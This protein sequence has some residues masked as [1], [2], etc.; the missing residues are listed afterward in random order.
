MHPWCFAKQNRERGFKELE[1]AKCIEKTKIT[2]R[3]KSRRKSMGKNSRTAW[4]FPLRSLP[5]EIFFPF[6]CPFHYLPLEEGIFWLSGNTFLHIPGSGSLWDI[7]CLY[8]MQ[9]RFQKTSDLGC[10]ASSNAWKVALNL[11]LPVR[12]RWTPRHAKTLCPLWAHTL[13][14]S[15]TKEIEPE[16]CLSWSDL[17]SCLSGPT[18][19]INNVLG[20]LLVVL[21]T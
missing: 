12:C 19:D 1:T 11:C 10:S 7:N 3:W 18:L 5:M 6:L 21:K 8:S 13:Y 2:H 20:T 9:S 14:I 17:Y 15:K 16:P 4:N